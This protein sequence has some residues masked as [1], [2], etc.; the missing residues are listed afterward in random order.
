MTVENSIYRNSFTRMN[1]NT[2]SATSIQTLMT[3]SVVVL[4]WYT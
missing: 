3:Y 2:I 1:A 4:V